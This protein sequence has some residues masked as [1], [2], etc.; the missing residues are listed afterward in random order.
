MGTARAKPRG[1][2]PRNYVFGLDLGGTKLASAVIDAE[3]CILARQKQPV[4]FAHGKKGFL[5]FL[6]SEISELLKSYPSPLA[7]GIASC[8]PLDSKN[9]VLLQPTNF[10]KWG[11]IEVAAYLQKHFEF[12]VFMLNDAAAGALAEGWQGGAQNLSRWILLTL[13]TGLGTGVVMER[14]AF[15]GGAGLGPELGHT[16]IS[17]LNYPC[18]CGNFGCAESVLSGTA[19]W[20]RI[21]ERKIKNIAS[22]FELVRAARRGLG[23]A[24]EIFDEYSFYL[25]RLVHNLAVPYFPQAIFLSGG[26]ASESDIFLPRAKIL[27]KK[28][29][30]CR[31]GFYPE[32]KVS[33]LGEDSG[34]LGGAYLA[35]EGVRQRPSVK[36][37]LK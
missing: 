28:L 8:G 2:K 20:K 24:L 35:W 11:K 14:R 7:I 18:G 26:L 13:G 4:D 27:A 19:L 34:V 6:R 15:L 22:T 29:L 37:N 9:G 10:P 23:P 3:G 36:R 32:I 33:K 16:I 25:A 17:D 30:D 31:P 1:S 12:P 21:Q 5:L